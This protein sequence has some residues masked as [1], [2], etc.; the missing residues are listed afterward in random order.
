MGADGHGVGAVQRGDRAGTA[1]VRSHPHCVSRQ[2]RAPLT[3]PLSPPRSDPFTGWTSLVTLSALPPSPRP[4]IC[5]SLD[6]LSSRSQSWPS[7][8]TRRAAA[9]PLAIENRQLRLPALHLLS[10]RLSRGSRLCCT[11]LRVVYTLCTSS[12]LDSRRRRPRLPHIRLVGFSTFALSRAQPHPASSHLAQ[13]RSTRSHAVQQTAQQG[14]KRAHAVTSLSTLPLPSARHALSRLPSVLSTPYGSSRQTSTSPCMLP[15]SRYPL[16]IALRRFSPVRS[17]PP[18]RPADPPGWTRMPTS[19]PSCNRQLRSA[20]QPSSL[21]SLS[22]R[23]TLRRPARRS[24]RRE[25]ARE[26]EGSGRWRR[27]ACSALRHG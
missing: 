12:L 6:L 14:E 13:R 10:E 2:F 4:S 19:S 7:S 1:Q 18:P 5:A 3:W 16:V 17:P 20:T 21:P 23:S 8:T 11:C 24:A 26:E 9:A 22:G 27:W 15:H 25:A